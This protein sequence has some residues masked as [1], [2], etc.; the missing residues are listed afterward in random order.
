MANGPRLRKLGRGYARHLKARILA[1]TN[2]V[3]EGGNSFYQVGIAVSGVGNSFSG[4]GF[5]NSEGGFSNSGMGS[6][7]S[8][9]GITVYGGGI[10]ISGEGFVVSEGL[11]FALFGVVFAVGFDWLDFSPALRPLAVASRWADQANHLWHFKAHLV[12]DDF[13]KGDVRD[14][15]IFSMGNHWPAG[16]A[17]AGIELAHA[18]RNQVHQHMSVFDFFKSFFDEFGIHLCILF[19]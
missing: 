1:L 5:C 9:P 8:G 7:D 11:V 19:L 2:G 12:F 15:E 13:A 17:V 18:P 4:V 10:G 16:A 3:S 14:A 6:G